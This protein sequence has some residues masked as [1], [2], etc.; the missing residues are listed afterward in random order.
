[1]SEF[2][3]NTLKTAGLMQAAS[4]GEAWCRFFSTYSRAVSIEQDVKV[5]LTAGGSI[6][7]RESNTDGAIPKRAKDGAQ[8][9]SF[10]SLITFSTYNVLRDN[11][12]TLQGKNNAIT[13]HL[14]TDTQFTN[15]QA[16]IRSGRA[17][18]TSGGGVPKSSA[19]SLRVSP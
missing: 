10:L 14:V 8:T 9:T 7:P 19:S 15:P 2:Y 16:T 5:T 4:R 18:N 13:I 11:N 1:V 12:T 6:N 3:E 17:A